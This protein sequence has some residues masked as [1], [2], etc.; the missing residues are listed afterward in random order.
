[1]AKSGEPEGLPAADLLEESVNK[2]MAVTPFDYFVGW[3][4]ATYFFGALLADAN[5]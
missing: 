4:C 5:D 3:V 2:I 1:M